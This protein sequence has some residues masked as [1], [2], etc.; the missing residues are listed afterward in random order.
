MGQGGEG[1]IARRDVLKGMAATAAALG[2]AGGLVPATAVPAHAA[3]MKSYRFVIVP[4]VVHP[5]FDAV[6]DGAKQ[7]AKLME[8]ATGAKFVID[9]RAPAKADVVMQNT[10]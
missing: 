5:W 1:S 7:Q 8:E 9:Y 6:V 10:I 4:K 2:A 3:T